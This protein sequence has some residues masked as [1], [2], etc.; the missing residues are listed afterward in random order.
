MKLVEKITRNSHSILKYQKKTSQ[1]ATSKPKLVT[2]VL[3][4][5]EHKKNNKV[6]LPILKKERAK[7]FKYGNDQNKPIAGGPTT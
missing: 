2:F 3:N 6:F 7:N 1:Y 5:N 4:S